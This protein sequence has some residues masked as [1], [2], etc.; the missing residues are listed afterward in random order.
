MFWIATSPWC[1]LTSR[2]LLQSNGWRAPFIISLFKA[3]WK[4][5]DLS[6]GLGVVCNHCIHH[7]KYLFE[8]ANIS[9]RLQ[10]FLP[11]FGNYH[12]DDQLW[13]FGGQWKSKFLKTCLKRFYFV[14]VKIVGTW[15]CWGRTSIQASIESDCEPPDGFDPQKGKHSVWESL[16]RCLSLS[17]FRR[18]IVKGWSIS[19]RVLTLVSTL[20]SHSKTQWQ[21]GKCFTQHYCIAARWCCWVV[22]PVGNVERELPM[23]QPHCHYHAV[24]VI[25]LPLQIIHLY[26]VCTAVL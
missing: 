25:E 20:V 4:G 9:S 15:R 1:L 26:D 14:Q 2:V 17:R 23:H 6:S 7:C 13:E 22:D 18:F 11:Q 12:I 19:S 24:L 5:L 3:C 10:I 21:V 8:I 16:F